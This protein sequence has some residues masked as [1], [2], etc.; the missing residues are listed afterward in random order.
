MTKPVTRLPSSGG[1]YIRDDKGRPVK[2]EKATAKP[3]A[4]QAPEKAVKTDVK[5]A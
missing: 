1:S 2:A 4:K 5:E 3:R